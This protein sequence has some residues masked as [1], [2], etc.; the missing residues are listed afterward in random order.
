MFLV[1]KKIH[2]ANMNPIESRKIVINE[3]PDSNQKSQS[4]NALLQTSLDDDMPLLL[5]PESLEEVF[6]FPVPSFIEKPVSST[7]HEG[8]IEKP[9]KFEITIKTTKKPLSTASSGDSRESK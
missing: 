4:N 8:T 7:M 2:R 1:V 6:H 9:M 3:R 5:R